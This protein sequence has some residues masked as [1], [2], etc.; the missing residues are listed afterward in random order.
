MSHPTLQTNDA[1]QAERKPGM[2]VVLMLST[3]LAAATIGVTYA[4]M[5]ATGAA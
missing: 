3:A 4:I 5:A 2:L 1:R